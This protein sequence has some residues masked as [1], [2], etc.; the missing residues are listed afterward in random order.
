[1][2]NRVRNTLLTIL[3]KENK[4]TV[5]PSEMDRLLGLGQRVIFEDNFYDYNTMLNAQNRRQ[6]NSDYSDIP[7]NI[8]EKIDLFSV[9]KD[10]TLLSDVEGEIYK[11]AEIDA[12]DLY[13]LSF[14]IVDGNKAEKVPKSIADDLVRENYASPTKD[15]PV[16]TKFMDEYRIYPK[17]ITKAKAVYIRKPKQPKWTYNTING[18]PIFNPDASDFQDLEIHPSDETKLIVKVLEYMGISIRDQEAY[19]YAMQK[20]VQKENQ[21]TPKS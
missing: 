20:N 18:D 19:Q 7:S 3:N 10:M 13:R 12:D 6:T 16:F 1:M 8:V 21:E 15:F 9:E 14:I 17:D 2:I 4:G 11:P 5:T